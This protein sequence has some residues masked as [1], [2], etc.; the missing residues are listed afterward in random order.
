[1]LLLSDP[2]DNFWVTT[3]L[4]YEGKPFESITQGEADLSNVPPLE[5]ADPE[6]GEDESSAPATA[7]LLGRLQTALAD[8][9]SDVKA[10]K[11]LVESPACL[12]APSGGP[13]RGLEKILE[14]QSGQVAQRPVLE[15]NLGHPIMKALRDASGPDGFEDVAWLLLDQARIL[16][17]QPPA[18]PAAFTARLNR[19]VL[20]GLD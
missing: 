6:A 20:S 13:D 2:V 17:G 12:V 15:V 4:G 19:F 14:K 7:E 3:A 18:D 11:R 1:V 9:V 8:E 10:S 5:D 16:E